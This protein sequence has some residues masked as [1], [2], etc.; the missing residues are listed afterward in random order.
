MSEERFAIDYELEDLEEENE[1]LK[2]ENEQLKEENVQLRNELNDCEKFRYAV[3]KKMGE[4][5]K[6]QGDV[7]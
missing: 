3:F 6:N 5:D 7:E 1:Q 4:I 2:K